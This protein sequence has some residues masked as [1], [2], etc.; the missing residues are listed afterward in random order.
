MHVVKGK[1]TSIKPVDRLFLYGGKVITKQETSLT[2][3][4]LI[5]IILV[6]NKFLNVR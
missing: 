3:T 4:A 6:H 2:E 5:Y 1:F